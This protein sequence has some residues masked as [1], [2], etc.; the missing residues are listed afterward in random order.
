MRLF[1][2]DLATDQATSHSIWPNKRTAL[3][4]SLM[5]AV[6]MTYASTLIGPVGID[7]VPRDPAEAWQI[8]LH[9]RFRPTGSDQRADWMGN[10]MMLVPYGF[11]VTA[12][13]WPRRMVWLK[14]LALLAALAIC[15]VTIVAIKY[16]QI[17]FPPRTVSLNY[18]TA[19]SVGSLAGSLG[20]IL[21]F[22]RIAR[23]VHH[24]DAVAG[25]V[26][27]LR[28][29][30]LALVL[31]LLMPLD[32][33]L[34]PA[35]LANQFARLPATISAIPGEGL[36]LPVRVA[37]Q[38]AA[39]AGFM[40]IGMLLAF[41]RTGRHRI[42]RGLWSVTLRGLLLSTAIYGLS[43]LVMGANP[44]VVAIAYRTAGVVI[45]AALLSW[46]V[47]QEPER[48]RTWAAAA[49]PY[50]AVVYLLTLAAVNRVISTE[51]RSWAQAM[52]ETYS[53]GRLPLFD[54]YIVTKADAA[55]NIVA[56][57]LMYMPLGVA[58]WL[59]A[60]RRGAMA[61]AGT[62][63]VLLSAAIEVARYLR[64]GLEGDINAVAVGGLAAMLT[65]P[66]M[67][68]AW[69]LLT[70]LAQRSAAAKDRQWDQRDT[71]APPA[72]DGTVTGEAEYY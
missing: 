2:E 40:P 28:L 63:G 66:L 16:L 12:T 65:V 17:F 46:L 33:A 22:E 18:I 3:V 19:Q 11:V 54:Y 55:K 13:L 53:L 64:P 24:G 7:Y 15:F 25:L 29:Y 21:W 32:F 34:D 68:L 5:L 8:L 35:D 50:L 26:V 23:V 45:G 70:E 52:A 31:F 43:T 41:R 27:A 14:P 51:W 61:L 71:D 69:S 58:V 1:Q 56:H 30:L 72:L 57:A 4:L 48:L 36:P 20:C 67:D 49:V 6:V 62:L 44:A 60:P 37:L 42:M 9:V 47:R 39:M 38:L 59:R 10:L